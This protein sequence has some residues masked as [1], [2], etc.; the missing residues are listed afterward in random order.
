[1]P[2]APVSSYLVALAI[3]HLVHKDAVDMNGVQVR[4]WERPGFEADLDMALYTAVKS[5]EYFA[6]FLDE[7]YPLPKLG[8]RVY[9]GQVKSITDILGVPQY[10]GGG[11]E[12]WGLITMKSDITHFNNKTQTTNYSAL[13]AKG[14]HRMLFARLI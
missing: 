5:V 13:V 12:N 3:G 9:S 6:K 10:K 14:A 1:M 2:L 4:V 8:T 7:P 11:M